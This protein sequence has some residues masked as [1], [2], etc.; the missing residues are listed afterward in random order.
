MNVQFEESDDEEG[1]EVI[2]ELK[3]E[4]SDEEGVEADYEGTLR[5]SH[6]EED[7]QVNHTAITDHIHAC[8]QGAGTERRSLQPRDID[9]HWI[10]RSLSKFYNDPIVAQQKVIEVLEILKVIK[11]IFFC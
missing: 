11:D 3:D 6:L 2:N 7:E 4:G 9:A 10:Q 5:A 1:E 8:L